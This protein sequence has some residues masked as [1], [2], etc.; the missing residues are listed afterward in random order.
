[1]IQF[2]ICSVIV[3]RIS[4]NP[5]YKLMIQTPSHPLTDSDTRYEAAMFDYSAGTLPAGPAFVVSAHL[6]LQP[7]AQALVEVFDA[8]GGALLDAL[9][10]APIAVPDWLNDGTISPVSPRQSSQA[11]DVAH[12][13]STLDQ[14]RWK[15][16]L[17]GMLVKP[18]AG[19]NAQLL[20][21][22]AGRNVPHHGHYG[23]EYTLVLSGE[24]DDG[25]G[26]Y[27]R[28]DLVIHDE[29]TEHQPGAT[30]MSDCICLISQTAPVRLNG[31]LGWL[32][33]RFS[34]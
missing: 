20:K 30:A 11:S 24:S 27:R 23:Q 28:G 19:V 5:T 31:P 3:T 33:N 13:L 29:D 14:G 26:T 34:R 6:A 25:H 16:N 32:I 17:A 12:M 15:R 21:L 10:P 8:T 7:R 1:M 9:E 2:A 4:F 22:E 18:V